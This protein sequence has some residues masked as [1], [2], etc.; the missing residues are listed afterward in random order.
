MKAII[1][2]AGVGKRLRQF[3]K[4]SPKC[5]IEF[6]GRSILKRL[7]DDLTSIGVVNIIVV[8]GYK[9][10]KIFDSLKNLDNKINIKY[11]VNENYKMGSVVSLWKAFDAEA[12][13]AEASGKLDEDVIIMD[14]DV[15]CDKRLLEKLISSPNKSCFLIDSDFTDTGEEQKIGVINGRALT[16]TKGQL[17]GYYDFV[18]EAVGFLKLSQKDSGL[19]SEALSDTIE[20]GTDNC[21]HEE[22]YDKILSCCHV[23]YETTDG[24]PWIEIDF[25]EDVKNAEEIV[26]AKL[27]DVKKIANTPVVEI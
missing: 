2:A 3:A 14:A 6:N 8:V 7:I 13:N 20:K 17:K 27:S 23:G 11:V 9:K 16:I 19:L 1:L 22:V 10:E 5:L 15:V 24:L 25:P 21:E 4:D 12:F 18:G 26:T